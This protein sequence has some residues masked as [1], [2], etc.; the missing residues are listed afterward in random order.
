MNGKIIF[1]EIPKL[2]LGWENGTPADDPANVWTIWDK[3]KYYLWGANKNNYAGIPIGQTLHGGGLAGSK[4][5]TRG[6]AHPHYIGVNTMDLGQLTINATVFNQ[7]TSFLQNGNDIVFPIFHDEGTPVGSFKYSLGTGI[8][9]SAFKW[10]DIQKDIFVLLLQLSKTASSVVIP[11][12]VFWPDCR[13]KNRLPHYA[14]KD[15]ADIQ[16]I[17]NIL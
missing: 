11:P 4:G 9:A 17:I 2:D 3:N 12:G 14:I 6:L 1:E 16:A 7:L 13:N 15:M 8:G 10:G 5:P